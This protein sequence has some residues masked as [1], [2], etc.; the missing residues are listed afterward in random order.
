M[1]E[2]N[3]VSYAGAVVVY[4]ENASVADRA[5]VDHA[6]YWL[7]ALMAPWFWRRHRIMQLLQA[8][9]G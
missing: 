7:C 3:R 9:T 2:A 5:V 6:W 1:A 4:L 8:I